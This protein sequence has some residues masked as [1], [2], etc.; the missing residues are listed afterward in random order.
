MELC[1]TEE[2]DISAVGDL[3]IFIKGMA[4]W[5]PLPPAVFL[6]IKKIIL[7]RFII[8]YYY[9]L[10]INLFI[11]YSW[12][13]PIVASVNTVCVGVCVCVSVHV[14]PYSEGDRE[15]MTERQRETGG[16]LTLSRS[17]L[18]HKSHHH[19]GTSCLTPATGELLSL[20]TVT[21]HVV[22]VCV[23]QC[24]W[25]IARAFLNSELSHNSTLTAS[26]EI[27]IMV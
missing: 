25:Q 3:L 19:F 16:V 10:F 24:V 21:V 2:K 9:S 23:C 22:A 14:L 5:D 13:L 15:R 18:R 7:I 4:Q 20:V 1:D 8:N 6:Y 17:L 12:F 11:S 26:S 27:N